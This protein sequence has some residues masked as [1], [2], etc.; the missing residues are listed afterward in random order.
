MRSKIILLLL[1]LCSTRALSQQAIGIH[2]GGDDFYG[3]QTGNYFLVD[4]Q[5]IKYSADN[6][7]NDTGTKKA[8]MWQPLIK[9]SYWLKLDRH[10]DFYAALSLA[11]LQ[12]P[13]SSKDS[14]YI[15]R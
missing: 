7:K 15:N 12:Y 10:F 5:N 9:V 6:Q 1:L 11:N 4:K 3:P 8:L 2:F 14:T 13:I